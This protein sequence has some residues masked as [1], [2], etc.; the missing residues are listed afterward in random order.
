M[1]P[2]FL[3]GCPILGC[4][5]VGATILIIITWQ[6][7]LPPRLQPEAYHFM[8]KWRSRK[9]STFH[10]R[11]SEGEG[12]L[13]GEFLS[14]ILT[15]QRHLQPQEVIHIQ[16]YLL[17]WDPNHIHFLILLDHRLV[18][19]MEAATEQDLTQVEQPEMVAMPAVNR[20]VRKELKDRH[21]I[22]HP[23]FRPVV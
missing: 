9:A 6:Q 10:I 16:I 4:F 12:T 22:H 2:D 18:L 3:W 14:R 13:A 23:K 7:L 19:I 8:R 1:L 5:L 21:N 20:L 15:L 11:K 17:G